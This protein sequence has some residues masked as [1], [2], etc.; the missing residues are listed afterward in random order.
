MKYTAEQLVAEFQRADILTEA[1]RR[2]L[3][4]ICPTRRRGA[5]NP[6]PRV[7]NHPA[8]P[9]YWDY[10]TI[11]YISDVNLERA[12]VG[13]QS[14]DQSGDHDTVTLNLPMS[15]L[16]GETSDAEIR[17]W[18]DKECAIAHEKRTGELKEQVEQKERALLASLLAKYTQ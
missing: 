7:N 2:V 8:I 14:Y 17:E 12:S 15:W 6:V 16:T 10:C 4:V 9:E 1:I 5:R 18:V 11:E 13:V 3:E